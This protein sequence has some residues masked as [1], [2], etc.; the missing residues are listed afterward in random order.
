[1]NFIRGIIWSVITLNPIIWLSK[2]RRVMDLVNSWSIYEGSDNNNSKR[3]AVLVLPW[4]STDV[5]WF[6]IVTGLFLAR[7]GNNVI[8]ILDDLP[9]GNKPVVFVFI[10]KCLRQVLKVISQKHTVIS[11]SN[12]LTTDALSA[13]QSRYV[14]RLAQFNAVWALKGEMSSKGRQHY[15]E[16]ILK[17]LSTSYRAIRSLIESKVFDVIFIPGGVYGSSGIWKECAL[18]AG[19]RVASFDS[20][21]YGTLMLTADG[22]ASQLQD[23]PRAF[24][25][26]KARP[27]FEQEKRIVFE[28]AHA[29]MQRR[30][31]GT[32]KF[33]SQMISKTNQKLH[34]NDAVLIALNSSW[35][36]AALG[37]HVVF[38]DSTQWIVET[39][40]WLLDNT[41][42]PVIIR[43]H[44][45][46]RLQIARTSDDYH[47]LLTDN[48]GVTDR[49]HFIA[50]DA[51]VN[52]YDLL[53]QVST[54]IVYTSTIGVEAATFGKVVITPSTS[55][56]SA[57]GFVWNADSKET[58]FRH[59]S[60]SVAQNYTVT[61]EMKDD[62][63]CCYYLTQC[64]NWVFSPF[65]PEGY[66][67]WSSYS[68]QELY[69]HKS[70]QFMI[71]SI[72]DNIPIA[73]LNHITN[74][75]NLETNHK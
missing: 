47:K 25:M 6:S 29:E 10:I 39:T 15:I 71:R 51:P 42:A 8:F 1:M 17:Q 24:A 11:L 64:C 32:D 67:D 60:N 9:F 63:M 4:L 3:F 22:I 59:I 61:P 56:Y 34:I 50:A 7:R 69:E 31:A 48:F 27:H 33:A 18:T 46:E 73:L 13:E 43:Q 2:T 58:Y 70:V 21:G 62:A 12:Y 74:T 55:Y 26:L 40:R 66:S 65:N 54:V 20:G 53:N 23:I 52:T 30:R 57:L 49:L 75:H 19:I 36:S 28:L 5:P 41:D 35:D 45:A 37:L 68:L 72:Q 38:E 14:Y 44:P 16:L